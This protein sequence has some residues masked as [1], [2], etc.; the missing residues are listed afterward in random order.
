MME[1]IHRTIER[2]IEQSLYKGKAVVVY[3][4]RRVG[5]TTLVRA[6]EQHEGR[7]SQYLN[8]DEP[9]VRQALTDATS[10]A[11]KAFIGNATLVILDEAQR[12]KNIG[13]TIKLL[14][15][16]Y[17]AMQ[18]IATGSSSFELSNRIREP[19]TGRAEEF[20]LLPLAQ[21]ELGRQV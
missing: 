9:D 8:C 10:T 6:I 5:K 21:H 7:P 17:P 18:V 19:L 15:D 11:L 16:T 2:Q 13:L 3:G 1:H 4:A 12:V 14:V 20:Q